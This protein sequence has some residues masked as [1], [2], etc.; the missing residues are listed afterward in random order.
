MYSKYT[1]ITAEQMKEQMRPNAERQVKLR[2]ALEQI[3]AQE[4]VEVT[5]ED[6]NAE[7]EDIAKTY[8]MEVE[9]VKE[10]INAEDINAD[11]KVKKAMELVEAAAT[12]TAE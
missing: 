1:G 7:Y 2:L 11:L 3:A 8:S 10:L 6:T 5:E 9:K 4:N 12:Y